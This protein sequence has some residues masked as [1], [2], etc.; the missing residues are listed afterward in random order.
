[1]NIWIETKTRDSD[2]RLVCLSPPLDVVFE[3]HDHA[4]VVFEGE[5]AHIANGRE[6]KKARRHTYLLLEKPESAEDIESV[7]DVAI[8]VL[9]A[10]IEMAVRRGETDLYIK[11]SHMQSVVNGVW[12]AYTSDDLADDAV[13]WFPDDIE[14][15][16]AEVLRQPSG[17]PFNTVLK[18][19]IS[20]HK[21]LLAKEL[22]D[23][24]E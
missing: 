23:A 15:E 10:S 12:E 21:C 2:P 5:D 22:A 17:E 24:D 3:R 8:D 9:R 19:F 13:F 18:T 7:V 11:Q 16:L 4:V 1:M 6:M 14:Y 20:D